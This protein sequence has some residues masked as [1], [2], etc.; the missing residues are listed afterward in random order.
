MSQNSPESFLNTLRGR[1]WLA[2][3]ALAIFN[4]VLGLLA[5][6]AASF[7][8]AEAFYLILF[9]FFLTTSAILIFGWW[10]ANEV[11]R[12]IENVSLLAK[13]LER[14]P[15]ASLPK[16][17]GSAE[18]DELLQSLYRASRQM[19]NLIGMMDDVAAGKTDT[20]LTPLQN[21]DKLSASFQKLVSKVTDSI[22]AKKELIAI[23]TA[24]MRLTNDTAPVRDGIL[25][26]E[27]TTD[28][29]Q[30]RD[31]SEVLASLIQ[32]LNDL[33]RSVQVNSTD[34]KLAAVQVQRAFRSAVETSEAEAVKLGRVATVLK[35][36]SG[37]VQRFCD[38]LAN[39]VARAVQYVGGPSE[40]IQAA[41]ADVVAFESIRKQ[42]S[43]AVRRVHKIRERSHAM[44][45]IAKIAEDLSRRSNL[46][47]LNTSLKGS[48]VPATGAGIS[49]LSEEMSSLSVRAESV[50]KEISAV[51]ESLLREIS[52]ME[53]VLEALNSEIAIAS[54]SA[55]QRTQTLSGF[56]KCLAHLSDI[57]V[58]LNSFAGEQVTQHEQALRLMGP[59]Y[60]EFTGDASP[61]RNSEG[62]IVRLLQAA[63]NLQQAVADLRPAQTESRERVRTLGDS[64]RDE[65]RG[66]A[67]P[68]L[69]ADPTSAQ[70][71]N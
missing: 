36:S 30:V 50:N 45:Q 69:N 31:I 21:S 24:V 11:L 8:T 44:P 67:D 1:I 53:A 29:P 37:Q 16:T 41:P 10:Q 23:E 61:L 68:L 51:N 12:P 17:T 59:S 64:M 60:S 49:L 2:A 6:L 71:E 5:Y 62:D 48:D 52:D 40:R 26:V 22:D 35:E 14:S 58:K 47:A 38:D 34:A 65:L 7:F 66:F 54:T 33:A 19:Q 28:L 56:D 42:V 43:E 20:A 39:S 18:T 3:G 70:Q 63:E 57:P 46:I 25:D 32:R 27:I 55:E 4:C 13:S 9:T 15:N